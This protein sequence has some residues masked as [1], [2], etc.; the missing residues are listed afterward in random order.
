MKKDID[1]FDCVREIVYAADRKS[2]ELLYLNKS[3]MEAFGYD[4]QEQVAGKKYY[5]V[6]TGWASPD[7]I[8]AGGKLCRDNYQEQIYENRETGRTYCLKDRLVDWD[9]REVRIE[10]ADDITETCCKK[11]KE[12][13]KKVPE[14]E[15]IVMECIRMMY[16]SVDTN[17]AINNTLEKMGLHLCADRTYI[18]SVYRTS[19]YNTHEW[20]A[21]GISREMD[22]LQN[23]PITIIDRWLPYFYQDECVIIQDL[24]QIKENNPEEYAVLKPQ[25]IKSLVT[26]PL[27]E[28]GKLVGYFGVDNPKTDNLNEISDILK[29]LAYFFQSLL[30][31]KRREDYLKKIG[32]TDG[33]TGAMNRNAFI[34]D[35]MTDNN[36]ELLSVGIFY[37]DI[38]GLKKTNDTYGHEAGDNLI[39]QVYQIICSVVE[40]FP[41]YRLG[42]DE[43]VVLCKDILGEKLGE[44]EE[45]LRAE[46]DGRNGC[47]AAIGVSFLENPGDL[48]EVID[49]ADRSMY[50]DKQQHYKNVDV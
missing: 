37:V 18:F 44:L 49:E 13:G 7:I 5:Q 4:N 46:L 31:R 12:E 19:M 33:M 34:R 32:F 26:V 3:G 1:I 38:N 45:Q 10:I 11:A 47:S 15:Q 25:N 17:E 36:R 20:C 2:H 8:C 6:L 23:V 24:E 27:M 40:V 28:Q 30:E 29:M 48:R 35:T 43:F 14:C 22:S 9:G 21:E 41:V 50:K 39:R 16:S 42:G